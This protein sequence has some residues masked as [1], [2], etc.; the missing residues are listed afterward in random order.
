MFQQALT[1]KCKHSHLQSDW[2]G[3]HEAEGEKKGIL[4]I[5]AWFYSDVY[6]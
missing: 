2:L 4:L 1:N 3:E 5:Q 6:I